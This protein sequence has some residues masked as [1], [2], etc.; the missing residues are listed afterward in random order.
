MP[1]QQLIIT[2]LWKIQEYKKY[3][4]LKSPKTRENTIWPN[5]K[6]YKVER[7]KGRLHAKP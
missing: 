2:K 1:L 6:T 5:K 3:V 4:I 7:K